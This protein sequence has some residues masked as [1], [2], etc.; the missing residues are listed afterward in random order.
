MNRQ[1][2]GQRHPRVADILINLGAAQQERARYPEAERFD[3]QALDLIRTF[4]AVYHGKHYL[5]GIAESNLGSALLALQQYTR[6][7][8]LFRDAIALYTETQS[9]E[10]LNVGIARIKLRRALLRQGRFAEAA[11][12]SLA[13]YEILSKQMAPGVSWLVFARKDLVA[14]YDSLKQPEKA[15]RFRAELADT[16][17]HKVSGAA[18]RP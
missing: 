16:A 6:G 17:T 10:H 8:P 9:P 13:G 14:A 4:L 15:A 5:I 7:E 1:L 3:R 12:E 18:A 11:T 2:Y